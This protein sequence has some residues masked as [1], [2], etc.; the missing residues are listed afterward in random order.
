VTFG[1]SQVK[2]ACDILMRRDK[3]VELRAE[4]LVRAET[5]RSVFAELAGLSHGRG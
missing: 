2:C 4:A 1:F 5:S 3:G